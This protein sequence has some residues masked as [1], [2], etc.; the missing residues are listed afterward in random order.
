MGIIITIINVVIYCNK[1]SK[2]IK[3]TYVYTMYT[4][5]LYN[6][7]CQLHLNKNKL[8]RLMCE[9]TTQRLYQN[10]EPESAAVGLWESAFLTASS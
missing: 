8:K 1:Y 10:T 9:Q 5:H 4:L 2:C 6:V 7:I 3:S